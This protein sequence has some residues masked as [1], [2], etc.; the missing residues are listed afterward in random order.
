[1]SESYHKMMFL[2]LLPIHTMRLGV[3]LDSFDG[4]HY[5]STVAPEGPVAKHG[6]LRPEDELL[7]V[8]S[9]YSALNS[10][11]IADVCLPCTLTIWHYGYVGSQGLASLQFCSWLALVSLFSVA[12]I[13]LTFASCQHQASRKACCCCC[14]WLLDVL[15]G[16]L[17]SLTEAICMT[18]PCPNLPTGL[19]SCPLPSKLPPPTWSG[20]RGPLCLQP[21]A[22]G[23]SLDG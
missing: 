13:T 16:G 3:E 5:I 1:M 22:V 8:K 15:A 17:L 2:Q 12:L 21:V 11:Y 9:F 4:H 20:G 6:L 10:I 14:C 7:E 23:R 19:A 18:V